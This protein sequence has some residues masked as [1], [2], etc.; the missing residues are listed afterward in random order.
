MTTTP[1]LSD[2]TIPESA[3][4]K[5][6]LTTIDRN[7][8]GVVFVVDVRSRLSGL[9]TDGDIRRLILAGK[10]LEVPVS[11]V[12]Q[13]EFTWRHINTDTKEIQKLLDSKIRHVPLVDDAHV[14]V[15]YAC[16]HRLHRIQVMEPLLTGNELSYVT[17]CI[18][19]NWISSQGAFVRRFEKMMGDYCGMSHALS[20]SNGTTALHLALEALN[21]GEGDEVIVPDL[22]FAATINCVLHANATPVIVDV[23]PVTWTISPELVR[24]AITPKTKAI[25]PVHLYGQP[26]DMRALMAIAK[27]HNLLVIEDCAE[28]LGS[29]IN[30][31][32]VGSFGDVSAFSFFGNKTITTGEGGMLLFRDSAVHAKANMLRD[33]GMQPGRR[34][35]HEVLGYNYRMTNLQAAVGVAQMERVDEFVKHKMRIGE[36]Y[37]S[38]FAGHEEIQPPAVVPG[39]LNSYWLFSMLLSGNSRIKRDELMSKLLSNGVETRPLFYPL[40]EMPLYQP[41]CKNGPFPVSKDI[42]YRGLSLPSAVTLTDNEVRAIGEKIVSLFEVKTMLKVKI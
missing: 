30:G 4:L 20:V 22:T 42:S 36:L 31:Q 2:I 11:T 41:F 29:S 39:S 17:E 10:S 9:L 23:D 38:C 18:K 7:A 26:C 35:W 13:R 3:L 34:Y 1:L 33:H 37:R 28:A 19:T 16:V 8:Q 32:M 40:H 12:M 24:K 6:A 14:L 25:I 21:I 27:E 5:D 15:D